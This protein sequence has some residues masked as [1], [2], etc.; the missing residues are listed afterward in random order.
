[1]KRKT[2]LKFPFR[3]TLTAY[4]FIE[5]F[6]EIDPET[7]ITVCRT[8][9]EHALTFT[10]WGSVAPWTRLVS[11]TF[12]VGLLNTL[13]N[14][15]GAVSRCF[16]RSNDCTEEELYNVHDNSYPLITQWSVL[17]GIVCRFGESVDEFLPRFQG[18]QPKRWFTFLLGIHK[19]GLFICSSVCIQKM[20][21]S[22]QPLDFLKEH[23]NTSHL[24]QKRC[25]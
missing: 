2:V 22:F 8:V 16:A 21:L 6:S 3:Q 9:R 18:S 24:Q 7:S 15:S 12:S 20:E 14:S 13:F 1:M 4:S 10:L 23:K 5:G 17:G 25:I 11:K 19:K